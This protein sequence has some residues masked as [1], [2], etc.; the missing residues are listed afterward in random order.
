MEKEEPE[1]TEVMAEIVTVVKTEAVEIIT[2]Q[3]MEATETTVS[4]T[5]M[6]RNRPVI[7]RQ[8]TDLE[9]PRAIL[10]MDTAKNHSSL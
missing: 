7:R 1:A 8:T 9:I 6:T 3:T 10:G 4:E 2:R 5:G